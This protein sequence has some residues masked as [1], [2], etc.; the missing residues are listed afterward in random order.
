[1]ISDQTHFTDI[2][3]EIQDIRVIKK[4]HGSFHNSNFF[5]IFKSSHDK[6]NCGKIGKLIIL[7][8]SYIENT[9]L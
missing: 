6:K 2:L 8:A 4:S 5:I 7:K 1:M 3:I 9:K